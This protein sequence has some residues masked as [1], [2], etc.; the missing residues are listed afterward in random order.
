VVD[1][2]AGNPRLLAPGSIGVLAAELNTGSNPAGAAH[3]LRRI[4]D[5]Q[6]PDAVAKAL[7]HGDARVRAESA[8]ARAEIQD[9]AT[10]KLLLRATRDA[11]RSVRTRAGMALDRL[12]TTAMVVGIAVLLEPMIRDAIRSGVARTK[13]DADGRTQPSPSP[14]SLGRAERMTGRPRPR[15]HGQRD[16]PPVLASAAHRGARF[17]ASELPLHPCRASIPENRERGAEP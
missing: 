8:P 1:R 12:G 13:V 9:P 16:S 11:E 2:A 3:V 10:V 5:P 6:T 15:V 17:R 14:G 4:G 7:E